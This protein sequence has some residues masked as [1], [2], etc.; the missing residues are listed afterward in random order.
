VLVVD[1]DSLETLMDHEEMTP[2]IR[3]LVEG[4]E[5]KGSSRRCW[6]PVLDVD[7][8]RNFLSAA[9]GLLDVLRS[10]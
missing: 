1:D 10:Q 2:S 4:S 6:T 5:P 9:R 8:A 7:T 3:N